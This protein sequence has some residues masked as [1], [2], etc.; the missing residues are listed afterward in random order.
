MCT[1]WSN[2]GDVHAYFSPFETPFEAY[3]HFSIVLADLIIKIES[4]NQLEQLVAK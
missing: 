3:R 2:D 4:E 1:K